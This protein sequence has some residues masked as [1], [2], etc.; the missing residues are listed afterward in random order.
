MTRNPIRQLRI[1]LVAAFAVIVALIWSAVAY[2]VVNTRES[3]M[4]SAAQGG[5]NLSGIVAE[6]FSSY[7][8]SADLLLQHLRT[9]WTRDPKHFS[10]AVALERGFRKDVSI[11]QVGVID[12]GGWLVYSD[13][14]NSKKRVFLGDRE[15]F[16]A[17]RSGGPDRLY[18]SDPV[19]GRVSGKF[20][21][22]FTRRILD[23]SGRFAGVLVLSVSPEALVR[24]YEGLDLG[25]DGLV[26]IRRL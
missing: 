20:S 8:G 9:Q 10:E 17:H 16:R 14:S 6:H 11:A 24:V 22:Q 1:Q 21:I 15:H 12:A 13:L 25:A 7:A 23:K 5:Q 4:R 2:Q 3:D 19:Q 18:I 26:A